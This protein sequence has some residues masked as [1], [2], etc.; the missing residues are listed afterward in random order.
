MKLSSRDHDA[1]HAVLERVY[2][3]NDVDEFTATSVQ[4]LAELIDADLSAFNEVNYQARRMLAVIDDP[5]VQRW[6]DGHQLEFERLMH[7]NPLITHHARTKDAPLRISDFISLEE[8][9]KTDIYN[10]FYRHASGNYQIAMVLP[11]ETRTIV[12][13]AFN[14][15]R[16]DFTERHRTMLTILQPHLTQAYKNAVAYTE[17]LARTKT[18]EDMLEAMEV[19]WIDLDFDLRIAGSA[20]QTVS[21]LK[22]F[23][24]VD[25][26]EADQL[27]PQLKA[28]VARYLDD[29]KSN[30]PV[31]PFI[32]ENATG[33]MVLRLFVSEASGLPSLMIDFAVGYDSPEALKT[34]GVTDR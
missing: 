14:R 15:A 23:F 5:D 20:P 26:F 16:S 19:G 32:V 7:Q 21:M 27:P 4:S 8:W 29:A 22:T 6:Y 34:L 18:R 33:R 1:V 3:L 13:F 12:A 31:D 17:S 11:V 30:P 2:A 24:E 28:W 9:R 10:A 25:A